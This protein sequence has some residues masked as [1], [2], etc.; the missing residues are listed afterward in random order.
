MPDTAESP[1][2]TRQRI[3]TAAAE[4]FAETGFRN[5][6][7]RQIVEK[8][9]ANIAAVNYHFGGK[10]QLYT[11]VFEQAMSAGF[12]E[13]PVNLDLPPDP[14]PEQRLLAF[15]RSFFLRAFVGQG[16]GTHLGRLILRE[17]VE[18]TAELN[19]RITDTMRPMAEHLRQ[20]VQQIV[21][22]PLSDDEAFL[23]STSII[24]QVVFH[25]HCREV[26][27]RMF[28]SR[29]YGRDELEQLARHV[30]DFSIAGLHAMR[31]KAIGK[32]AP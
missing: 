13:Y 7:I 20:I 32:R 16:C 19:R 28:P 29:T 11:A 6:T 21:S 14:T 24:S 23:F 22:R 26:I 12:A 15:V 1:D 2:K 8:A 4:V 17:M 18:P 9:G 10:N 31:S 30:T 5:A 3:L 27:A 25:K